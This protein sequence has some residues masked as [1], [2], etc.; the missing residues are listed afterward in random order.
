MPHVFDLLDALN[1]PARLE[2]LVAR[3][4]HADWRGSADTSGAPGVAVE[5]GRALVGANDWEFRVP[6]DFGGSGSDVERLLRHYGI[7]VWGQRVTGSY[8]VFNVKER[9]ANWAEYL[10]RRA[11]IPLE[12]RSFDAR[13][14]ERAG[15]HSPGSLPPAW[16]DRTPEEPT[17]VDRFLDLLG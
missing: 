12:N 13:N 3:V 1:W 10:L 11:G 8:Y 17:P 5:L 9:Q 4:I 15:R 7:A 16:A 14:L 2:G 6:R